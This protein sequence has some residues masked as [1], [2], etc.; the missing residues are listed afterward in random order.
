MKISRNPSL[1]AALFCLACASTGLI[2]C[3]TN[4]IYNDTSATSNFGPGGSPV[5]R[6][7]QVGFINNTPFRAIFTFGAY[8]QFDNEGVPTNT[9][10]LRLEGN[11]ASNQVPQPCRRSYSVGGAELVRLIELNE[12]DPQVVVTDPAALMPG[13]EASSRWSRE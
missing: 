8:D 2:A 12:D 11:T 4:A 13:E 9:G 10:Q 6:V 5:P 3:G 7:I 1:K